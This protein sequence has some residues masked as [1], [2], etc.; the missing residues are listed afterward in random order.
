MGPAR[1]KRGGLDQQAL[2]Q[3]NGRGAWPVVWIGRPGK[4]WGPARLS[5]GNLAGLQDGERFFALAAARDDRQRGVAARDELCAVGTAA[6]VVAAGLRG[7]SCGRVIVTGWRLG[8]AVTRR[9]RSVLRGGGRVI[10]DAAARHDGRSG[11][12]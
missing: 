5:R 4:P 10:R 3:G 6:A 7:V 11:V 9:H 2:V 8:L 1:G 12:Q